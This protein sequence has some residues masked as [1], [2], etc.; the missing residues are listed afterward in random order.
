MN[1]W[2]RRVLRQRRTFLVANVLNASSSTPG[3]QRLVNRSQRRHRAQI[4]VQPT[5]AGQP[6]TDGVLI[7]SWGEI[8]RGNP[9]V[10]GSMGGYLPIGTNMRYEVQA[11]LWVCYPVSNTDPVFV[12]VCD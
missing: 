1:P 9:A 7:G 4:F 3:A 8:N 2:P 10:I 11:E 5:V 12:T 6:V